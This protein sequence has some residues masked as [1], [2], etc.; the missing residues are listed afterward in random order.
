MGV[1]FDVRSVLDHLARKRANPSAGSHAATPIVGKADLGGGAG[2][3][4]FGLT[5]LTIAVGVIPAVAEGGA[6]IR[7]FPSALPCLTTQR[8]SASASALWAVV[9]AC[10]AS[11]TV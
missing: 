6:L 10:T 9:H 7:G 8:T 11:K 5:V 4:G 3:Q 2:N 1:D